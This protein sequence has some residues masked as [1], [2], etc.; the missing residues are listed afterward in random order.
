MIEIRK[1]EIIPLFRF[2]NKHQESLDLQ[3]RSLFSRLERY[4]YERLSIDEMETL[5]GDDPKI[6]HELIKKL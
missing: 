2:C 5:S 4:L 3:L 6:V 1:E